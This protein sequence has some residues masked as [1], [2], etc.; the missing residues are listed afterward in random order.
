MYNEI[1]QAL[2]VEGDVLLPKTF[3]VLSFVSVIRWTRK[4][5]ALEMFSQLAK[6]PQAW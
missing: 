5:P 4:L 1:F 2:V 6:H 3:L